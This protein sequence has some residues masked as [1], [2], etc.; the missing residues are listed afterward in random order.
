MC[1]CVKIIMDDE[2]D[3][4]IKRLRDGER[5]V[6]EPVHEGDEDLFFTFLC[7]EK[8]IRVINQKRVPII[9]VREYLIWR[10]SHIHKIEVN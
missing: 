9:P 8:M 6:Y 2:Y 4:I 3:R 1:D 5:F 10:R 7:D